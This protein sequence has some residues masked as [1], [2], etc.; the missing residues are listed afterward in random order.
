M[1]KNTKAEDLI[2]FGKKGIR[3]APNNIT[4]AGGIPELFIIVKVFVFQ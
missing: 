1:E 4:N 2:L 3:T